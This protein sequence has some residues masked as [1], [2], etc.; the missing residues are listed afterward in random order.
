MSDP[1]GGTSCLIFRLGAQRFYLPV[2]SVVHVMRSV[3]VTRVP[4]TASAVG[5][6]VNHRGKVLTVAHMGEVLGIPVD[7]GPGE[8]VVVENAGRRFALA[9]DAVLE[10]SAETR[11]GL[12]RIDLDQVAAAIF[13]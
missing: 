4:G 11:T 3:A 9:V 10:L 7:P 12:A 6:L 1:A 8:V 13:A 2:E 5:G